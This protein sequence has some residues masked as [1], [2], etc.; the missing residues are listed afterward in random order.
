MYIID[1]AKNLFKKSNIGTIIWMVA[2]TVL[3]ALLF[4]SIFTDG[5][6]SF[7]WQGCLIGIGIYLVSIVA[8]LS[9]FGEWILRFQNGCKEI[10]DPAVLSR[11]QPLFDEVHRKAISLNPELDRKIK[12]YMVEDAAPN[13][14]ACGRNTVA[15]TR[16]LLALSD[17]EIKAILGHE[18]GH[19]AH[20]D[21]DTTLVIVVGNL[22]VSVIFFIIRIIFKI[23]SGI[24]T[25]VVSVASESFLVTILTAI[26]NFFA[27]IVLAF[28]MAAWTR[29]GVVICMASSRGNEYEADKYSYQLGYGY[30]LANGLLN[31]DRMFGASKPK[32]LWAALNSSHPETSKRVAKIQ[33]YQR[34]GI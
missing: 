32:G 19:L 1:F 23:F 7:G 20:K 4:G 31:L 30:D 25:F 28:L 18:F 13:A 29:L 34:T 26:S 27:N 24:L 2:N 8:A 15:I 5:Y 9:P 11:I 21:T 3:I 16:G 33:E 12:L 17:N 10:T 6:S 22:I 14:F